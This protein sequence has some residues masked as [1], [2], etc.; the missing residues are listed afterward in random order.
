[1]KRIAI[2]C[3]AFLL[4]F[5]AAFAKIASLNLSGEDAMDKQFA[6][7]EAYLADL[8]DEKREEWL[9]YL[10]RMLEKKQEEA[11]QTNTVMVWVSGKGKK[12]HSSGSC[13][14]MKNPIQMSREEA[15]QKGYEP[16]KRCK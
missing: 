10:S 14:R 4:V 11:A 8:P 1:M 3:L 12:Y 5:G 7:F 9:N 15:I 16:C 2:V 13:S 6:A